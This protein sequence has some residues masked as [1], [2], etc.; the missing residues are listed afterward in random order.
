MNAFLTKA[1]TEN[2]EM[3]RE[4]LRQRLEHSKS[5]DRAEQG[6]SERPSGFQTKVDVRSSHKR[7]TDATYEHRPDSDDALSLVGQVVERYER[8][9]MGFIFILIRS[10][11]LNV[12][13]VWGLFFV[14]LVDVGRGR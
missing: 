5:D 9:G 14:G 13:G 6:G 7:T 8:V 12:V 1:P 4:S 11:Q 3:F 2:G 10:R